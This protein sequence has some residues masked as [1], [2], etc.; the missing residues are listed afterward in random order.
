M[1]KHMDAWQAYVTY[2]KRVYRRREGS[3]QVLTLGVTAKALQLSF[4]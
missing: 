4:K 2:A 1:S 3:C